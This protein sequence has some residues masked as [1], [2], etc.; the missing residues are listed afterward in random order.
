MNSTT[1][2]DLFFV[3]FLIF[4]CLLSALHV[5]LIA[6]SLFID[7]HGTD[8]SV[9]LRLLSGEALLQAE[10]LTVYEWDSNQGR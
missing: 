9:G 10:N 7:A 5:S 1:V 8:L 4:L 6:L 3:H 2:C